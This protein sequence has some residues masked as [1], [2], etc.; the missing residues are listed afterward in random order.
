MDSLLAIVDGIESKETELLVVLTTNERE[1][2]HQAMLRP[3]R[4]DSIINVTPPDPGA[5]VRLVHLYA[6]GLVAEG[7]DLA[8]VG[9]RLSGQIPAVIRECVERSKLHALR[10]SRPG[11]EVLITA[12]ALLSA[13][14]EMEFALGLLKAKRPDE[15]SDIEKAAD[16]LSEALRTNHSIDKMPGLAGE[17]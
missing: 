1:K 4:L 10:L 6:R 16:R 5:V 8:P 15:R 12:A 9:E 3:R 14:D 2:I 11:E 13:A 17:S 7:Q